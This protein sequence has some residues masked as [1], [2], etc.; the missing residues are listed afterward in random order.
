VKKENL[1]ILLGRVELPFFPEGS[2]EALP[3]LPFVG[4]LSVFHGITQS[5][6][7]NKWK[8]KTLKKENHVIPN[9]V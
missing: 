9:L 2:I 6:F 1:H 3:L 5:G 4:F 7:Q 8:D